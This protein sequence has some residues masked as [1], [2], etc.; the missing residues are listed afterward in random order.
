MYI[1]TYKYIYVGINYQLQT[2]TKNDLPK[3]VWNCLDYCK[4]VLLLVQMGSYVFDVDWNRSS[5]G[6]HKQKNITKHNHK[7]SSTIINH[8][9]PLSRFLGPGCIHIQKP[10]RFPPPGPAA[11]LGSCWVAPR[12]GHAEKLVKWLGEVFD[13]TYINTGVNLQKSYNIIYSNIM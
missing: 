11:W 3:N 12:P 13:K 7:P 2:S 4:Y 5:S 8:N 9:K 1:Y 10:K 6:D